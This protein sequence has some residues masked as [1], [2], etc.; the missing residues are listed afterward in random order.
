MSRD[1]A[2]RQ[3]ASEHLQTERRLLAFFDEFLPST[4]KT[5][6]TSVWRVAGFLTGALPALIGPRAVFLTIESVEEFVDKHYAGQIDA[7]AAD[8]RLHALQGKLDEFRC[9]EVHHMRDA[10]RRVGTRIHPIGQAWRRLV[11]AGSNLGVFLAR[12]I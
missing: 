7:L 2:I 10:G 8:L 1:P 12:R 9:E 6:L 4:A 3:F 5:R 11:G